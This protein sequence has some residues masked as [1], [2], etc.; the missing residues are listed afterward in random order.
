MATKALVALVLLLN[1]CWS[2]ILPHIHSRFL[3]KAWASLT[4]IR[5]AEL[6]NK[7]RLIDTTPRLY[8]NVELNVAYIEAIG[9]DMD[10]T[11]AQVIRLRLT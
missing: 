10:F 7:N 8:C 11:L 9:F 2:F 6:R 5:P 1:H 3:T 4:P